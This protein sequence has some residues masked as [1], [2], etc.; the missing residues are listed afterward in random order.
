MEFKK[1]DTMKVPTET[2]EMNVHGRPYVFTVRATKLEV[3]DFEVTH[4]GRAGWDGPDDLEGAMVAIEATPEIRDQVLVR[5]NA[6]NE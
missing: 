6:R 2:M 3:S 5:L 4:I 1:E